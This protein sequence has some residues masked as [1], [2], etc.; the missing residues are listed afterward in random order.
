MANALRVFKARLLARGEGKS[1]AWL[2][3]AAWMIDFG[4]AGRLPRKIRC[5]SLHLRKQILTFTYTLYIVVRS[6]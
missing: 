5:I 2:D 3:F 4:K 6:A 1:K